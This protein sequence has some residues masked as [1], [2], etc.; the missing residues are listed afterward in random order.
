MVYSGKP[1]E[2]MDDLGIPPIFGNTHILDCCV[3]LLSGF[4]MFYTPG[5]EGTYHHIPSGES[6]KIIDSKVPA[7]RQGIWTRSREGI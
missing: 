4:T 5:N 1:Y 7:K 2:Q 3:G 6:R